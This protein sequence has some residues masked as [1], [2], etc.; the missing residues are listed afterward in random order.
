MIAANLK[1]LEISYNTLKHLGEIVSDIGT[2]FGYSGYYYLPCEYQS[3]R[4]FPNFHLPLQ[5]PILYIAARL[6]FLKDVSILPCLCSEASS[7]SQTKFKL[8]SLHLR[9]STTF[10]SLFPLHIDYV[11]SNWSIV[12]S[13]D[14]DTLFFS[15]A[16]P[17]A[18]PPP[19]TIST[20]QKVG[21]QVIISASPWNF[22]FLPPE[23]LLSS[24]GIR[25]VL[26]L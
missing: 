2:P 12:H 18:T 8:F 1:L 11:R 14:T 17:L 16:V 25:T 4:G 20:Y 22:W 5:Q 26:L 13:S 6:I 24:I 23:V 21:H 7:D 19:I 3:F 9:T 15:E 10:L